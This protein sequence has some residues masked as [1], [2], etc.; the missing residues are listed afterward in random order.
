MFVISYLLMILANIAL[1]HYSPMTYWN[2]PEQRAVAWLYQTPLQNPAPP[3]WSLSEVGNLKKN[4][5][6]HTDRPGC[7]DLSELVSLLIHLAPFNSHPLTELDISCLHRD[8][9]ECDK[10][11]VPHFW[12]CSVIWWFVCCCQAFFS[13]RHL[14]VLSLSLWANFD[15]V[16]GVRQAF[17]NFCQFMLSA[18][19]WAPQERCRHAL[20]YISSQGSVS[21][22]EDH[23]V[24]GETPQLGAAWVTTHET[25]RRVQRHGSRRGG[26]ALSV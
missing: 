10:D 12:I 3:R 2:P 21:Y 25:A 5:A 7:D 26:D 13:V 16:R 1:Y 22:F 19:V 11:I 9:A 18:R 8:L 4:H 15:V 23:L 6:S 14:P 20:L 24:T 17:L